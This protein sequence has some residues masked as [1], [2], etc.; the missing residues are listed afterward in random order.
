MCLGIEVLLNISE[1][2]EKL[3]KNCHSDYVKNQRCSA[4]FQRKS[5]L[6]Q[7][8]FIALKF[9]VFSAVQSWISAVHRF[10]GSEHRWN[11]PEIILNQSWS[12][13]KVSETSTRAAFHQKFTIWCSRWEAKVVL[14]SEWLCSASSG[15]PWESCTWPN[16]VKRA[17]N[18][19]L[20]SERVCLWISII[21]NNNSI[22][23]FLSFISRAQ[24]HASRSVRKFSWLKFPF[25]HSLIVRA[26]S[27]ISIAAALNPK[28]HLERA[29]WISQS[30]SDTS[31]SG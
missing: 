12:A 24:S 31:M 22:A 10:S 3:T 30:A 23:L 14:T 13:L 20:S 26:V 16:S 1:K 28:T 25:K 19:I 21:R 8:W 11:R 9:F 2:I 18:T 15:C 7:R 17:L 27:C 5:A 6:K 29:S 4:L